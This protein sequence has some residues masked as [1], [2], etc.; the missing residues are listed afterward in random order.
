MHAPSK[1]SAA[2]AAGLLL[3][4]QASALTVN[5]P[6]SLTTCQP[7]MLSWTDADGGAQP[8]TAEVQLFD[9]S[10][11]LRHTTQLSLCVCLVA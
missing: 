5:S 2:T 7:V 8:L 6:A 9:A 1:L 11:Q 10:T 3:A 4:M